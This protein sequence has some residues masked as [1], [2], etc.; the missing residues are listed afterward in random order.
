[1]ALTLDLDHRFRRCSGVVKNKLRRKTCKDEPSNVVCVNTVKLCKEAVKCDDT[2]NKCKAKAM[3]TDKDCSKDTCKQCLTDNR[4]CRN[5][6][7]K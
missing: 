3:Q 1:L 7:L 2:M 6:A 4:L 5:D